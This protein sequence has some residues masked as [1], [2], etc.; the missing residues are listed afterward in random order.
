MLEDT[1]NDIHAVI[2]ATVKNE[3]DRI[4]TN[5]MSRVTDLRF[6][7]KNDN[8]QEFADLIESYIEEW[9]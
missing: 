4:I 3:Q 1:I 6:C 9:V 2:A 8:C 5:I 7:G